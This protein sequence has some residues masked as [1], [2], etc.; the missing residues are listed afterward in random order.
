MSRD[1]RK[2]SSVPP[3][4]LLFLVAALCAQGIWSRYLSDPSVTVTALPTPPSASILKVAAL[5]QPD[6]LA[7][8]LMLWLQAFDYQPGVSIAF[9]DLDY[10]RLEV[11][12][13][14]ILQ[15]DPQFEYP[16]LAAAR[17]YGEVA[18]E[19]KQRRMLKFTARQF[20][21]DPQARWQWMAHAVYIAKHRLEDLDLALDLARELHALPATD[22]IPSWVRQMHIFVLEDMGELESAKVLLGGLLESGEIT[23]RHEQWFLSQRLHELEQRSEGH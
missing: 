12:L 7:R 13:E 22:A 4:L 17:L 16:L 20:R 21:R 2:I 3:L 8:V 5:G 19:V 15:L 18:D 14:R 10:V 23:D 11:W 6:V 1:E 9:R